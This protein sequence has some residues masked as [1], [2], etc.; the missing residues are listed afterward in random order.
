MRIGIDIGGTFTDLVAA[1]EETGRLIVFKCLTTPDDLSRCFIEVAEFV[2]QEHPGEKFTVVHGTTV[3]TNALLQG[4]DHP[5]GM[6]TTAGFRDVLEFGRHFRRRVYDLFLQK[7]QVLIPRDL[8]MEVIERENSKGETLIP[9]QPDSLRAAAFALQ[10][11]GVRSVAVCFIN[12]YACGKH[13]QEA[14]E[15]LRQEFPDLFVSL[16]SD[17]CPE[18][19]EFER[20]STTAVNTCVI[21]VVDDYVRRIESYASSR[22]ASARRWRSCSQTAA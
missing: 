14:K 9:L 8:R 7:P 16:S 10:E 11:R 3:A 20:F 4:G 1:D 17:V 22:E 5:V 13:D 15:I 12:A 19:R 18:P 21:P 6:I 2:T